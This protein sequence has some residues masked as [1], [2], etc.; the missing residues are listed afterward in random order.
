V[1]SICRALDWIPRKKKE[2][3]PIKMAKHLSRH[4]TEEDMQKQINT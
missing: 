1:L 2:N 4:I 3:I